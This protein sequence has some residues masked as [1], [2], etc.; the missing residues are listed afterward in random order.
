MFRLRYPSFLLLF[1]L[2]VAVGACADKEAPVPI[3]PTT[4]AAPAAASLSS[5]STGSGQML[6]RPFTMTGQSEAVFTITDTC[7]PGTA[8][9]PMGCHF[10]G[11]GEGVALHLGKIITTDI[12]TFP[13]GEGT[14]VAANGD[15]LTFA[16]NNFTG[17]MTITGGTGRFAG[18]TGSLTGAFTVV[19][20]PVFGDGVVK[21]SVTWHL[22]GTITY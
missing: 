22:E 1:I 7:V 14:V 11:H 17:T 5:S 4:V 20:T 9:F 15:L 21:T 13:N 3:A 18:A 10:E 19:G 16:S 8:S 6:E 2:T 12:G